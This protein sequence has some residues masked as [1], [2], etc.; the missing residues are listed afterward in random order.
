MARGRFAPNTEAGSALVERVSASSLV[1]FGG[2]PLPLLRLHHA[3]HMGAHAA[4]GQLGLS[5][6]EALHAPFYWALR[7]PQATNNAVAR[8]LQHTAASKVEQDATAAA[9][10]GL[11]WSHD[12]RRWLE[13]ACHSGAA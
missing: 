12:G 11:E 10:D 8:A 2:V 7:V 13:L 5:I 6:F 1:A 4:L 9:L 3:A